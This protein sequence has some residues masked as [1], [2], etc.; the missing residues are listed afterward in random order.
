MAHRNTLSALGAPARLRVVR[1]AHVGARPDARSCHTDRRSVGHERVRARAAQP[2]SQRHITRHVGRSGRHSVGLAI[3]S[4]ADAAP[5][6]SAGGRALHRTAGHARQ[7]QPPG[8]R[9]RA[10]RAAGRG[11]QSHGPRATRYGGSPGGSAGGPL[12]HDSRQRACPGAPR[13]RG[14]RRR[15]DRAARDC[16]AHGRRAAHAALPG[17]RHL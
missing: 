10:R 8:G 13:A 11:A 9:N 2:H 17:R 3:H 1:R 15:A 12:Q 6:R 4:A 14:R 7:R 5:A 16:N